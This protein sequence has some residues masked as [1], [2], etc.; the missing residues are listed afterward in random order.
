MSYHDGEVHTAPQECSVCRPIATKWTL[1]AL[2]RATGSCCSS[3]I[4]ATAAL[5]LEVKLQEASGPLKI[6][7]VKEATYLA[8]QVAHALGSTLFRSQATTTSM[9]L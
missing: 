8:S 2:R 5:L 7:P 1:E 9:A 3:F 4:L 6:A